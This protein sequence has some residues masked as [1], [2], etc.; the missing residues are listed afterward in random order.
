[1]RYVPAAKKRSINDILSHVCNAEEFYISRLGKDADVVYEQYLG[2]P[3][4]EVDKLPVFNRL[5]LV[6]FAAVKTLEAIIPSK[7]EAVFQRREYS[8]YPEEQWTAFKILRR[9]LEHEREHIFNIREYL[10]LQI[11]QV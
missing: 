10:N 6:R 3:V 11:R 9:F 7:R 2:T 5:E 1:L 4:F 8:R